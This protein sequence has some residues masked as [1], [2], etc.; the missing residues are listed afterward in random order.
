MGKDNDDA[1]EEDAPVRP[2]VAAVLMVSHSFMP[3]LGR[4]LVV[5]TGS[6]PPPP[7]PYLVI[8][9]CESLSP[10]HSLVFIFSDLSVP[11]PMTRSRHRVCV[12]GLCVLSVDDDEGW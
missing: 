8:S 3:L 12:Y 5:W 9:I 6:D 1:E 11:V 10:F 2:S 7:L 4:V